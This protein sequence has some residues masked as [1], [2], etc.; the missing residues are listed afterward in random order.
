MSVAENPIR[1]LAAYLDTAFPSAWRFSRLPDRMNTQYDIAVSSSYFGLDMAVI[2]LKDIDIVRNFDY[3]PAVK[4]INIRLKDAALTAAIKG[5]RKVSTAP[6]TSTPFQRQYAYSRAM[7][8]ILHP[9]EHLPMAQSRRLMVDVLMA[10]YLRKGQD[11]L[12]ASLL[13]WHEAILT[14]KAAKTG[15]KDTNFMQKDSIQSGEDCAILAHAV[16]SVLGADETALKE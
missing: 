7:R 6:E 4:A 13:D 3:L 12:A 16:A 8:Y 14:L 1:E 15:N 11:T 2:I 5:L 10:D 9:A